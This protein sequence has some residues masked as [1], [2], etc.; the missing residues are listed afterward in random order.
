LAIKADPATKRIPV[1]ALRAIRTDQVAALVQFS[2]IPSRAIARKIGHPF[3]HIAAL[4]VL[5]DKLGHV[6]PALALTSRAL[7]PQ[8]RAPDTLVTRPVEASCLAGM[9][10]AK[11]RTGVSVE[12]WQKRHRSPLRP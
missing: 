5:N 12:H 7:N 8:L 1:I 9:D 2:G 3:A 6:V 11:R 4:A 10:R